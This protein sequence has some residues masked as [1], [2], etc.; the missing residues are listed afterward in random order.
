MSARAIQGQKAIAPQVH[1][2]RTRQA[3]KWDLITF[4]TMPKETVGRTGRGVRSS[5]R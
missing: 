5:S 2:T 1:T 4:S 3:S